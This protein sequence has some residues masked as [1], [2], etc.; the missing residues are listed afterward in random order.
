MNSP[1]HTTGYNRC[2]YFTYAYNYTHTSTN[3]LYVN[4]FYW[5]YCSYA[6]SK[7]TFS[8]LNG[9]DQQCEEQY[10]HDRNNKGD[11]TQSNKNVDVD[12]TGGV[13]F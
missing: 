3:A 1:L 6:A 2:T 4:Y 10:S 9:D 7:F 12:I 13:R 8:V 11:H 5:I